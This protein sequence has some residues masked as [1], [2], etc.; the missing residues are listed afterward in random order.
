L[1]GETNVKQGHGRHLA[2][3]PGKPAV[4]A[5]LALAASLPSAG[6]TRVESVLPVTTFSVGEGLPSALVHQLAQDATGRIWILNREGIVSYDGAAFEPQGIK[7]GLTATQ[8]GG[9]TVDDRG[10]AVV[11]A[12]DGRVYRY[13]SGSWAQRTEAVG[14]GVSGQVLALAHAIRNGREQFLVSTTDSLWLFDGE[15][16]R[17]QDR[18]EDRLAV[19]I[20]SLNQVGNELFVGTQS[21][22]CRIRDGLDC[23]WSDDPRLRQPILALNAAVVEGRPTLL[24]LS[25]RWLGALVDG[26]LRLFGEPLPF[27]LSTP[28]DPRDPPRTA[29]AAINIDAAGA[30]FFGT[31][32]HRYLLEPGDTAPRELGPAQ[33]FAGESG[34]SSILADREGAIW[35]GSLRGLTRVGSRRFLSLDARSGLAEDEVTAI[36]ARSAGRFLLGHNGGLTFMDREG[37][38]ITAT[39]E[40]RELFGEVKGGMPRFLDFARDLSGTIWGAASTALIEVHPDDR[41]TT[42][43][44]PGRVVSVEV[45]H[46][47]R[48]FV[49]GDLGLY[50]RRGGRFEE[51]PFAFGD[52]KPPSG[53]RWLATDK[54]GRLF[55]AS[56]KGLFWRDGLDTPDV[57]PN[58][59]WHRA[60]SR[61]LRG[62]NVYA[63]AATSRG[64]TIVGTA[65]GLYRLVGETLEAMGGALTLS[66]PVY[67]LLRDRSEKLWAGTD[68]G[69]FI[70]E[71]EGFR[72]LSTRHGLMGLETNR[73]AG[74]VDVAGRIWIGTDHGLSIYRE[75]LDSRLTSPPSVEIVGVDIEGEHRPPGDAITLRSSPRSVVFRGR[76][77]TFSR[78][79]QVV[80][81]YRLDGLDEDWQGPAPLTTAGLRYTSLPPGR[82]R[83]RIAAAWRPGGPFGP[84]SLSQE[85]E[86]PTPWW[87]RPSIW[88]LALLTAGGVVLFAHRFRLQR[89]K[90]RNTQ[91]ESFNA[92]LRESVAERQRLISELEAKNSEL[93]RFT[94]TVSHDLKAPLV[95]IRGFAKLVEQDASEGRLERVSADIVRI[96]KAAETMGLLLNQLLDLSRIGRVV[97]PAENLPLAPLVQEAA[98]RVPGIEPVKLVVA[99]N[100]PVVS[101]DRTRLI[102]V[103]ENLLGNSVKFMGAQPSPRIEVSFRS[104]PEPLIVVSDNGVGIDPRFKEKAFEL[105]ER[106]DKTVPGTGVGLAIVKRIVEFHGGR[107]WI[108][109]TGVPGEGSRFCLTLPIAPAGSGS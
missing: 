88:F 82:Y 11:A 81:R 49:L 92:Q 79:E 105:F 57:D 64:E 58:A 2:W 42:H 20:T 80:C 72:Q 30:V 61:D 97:G 104:G 38:R 12:F 13:E 15:T 93:E 107:I 108:E 33:G 16:W 109:S 60:L 59:V 85:I 37:E 18:L 27:D 17:R 98:R 75:A 62:D 8:F 69:V 77:I 1:P 41:V 35:L 102:E 22:L 106:L 73:G 55:V 29:T 39:K 34:V 45:D 66:R 90:T 25:Q 100:L 28:F 24:V 31:R 84:E 47:G 56:S 94:Y 7:H 76:T 95:T 14:H 19:G 32:H 4:V 48:L 78:E 26:R 21:G 91:L 50:M 10:Q 65:G 70:A 87:Q 44:L 96:Q 43:R 89:L 71:P 99:P 46:R 53:S 68:D 103:F 52:E 6:Q 54:A 67:F 36:S 74:V 83:L 5:I 23:A 101:G 3:W 40:V 86:I 9:L 63:V 51:L